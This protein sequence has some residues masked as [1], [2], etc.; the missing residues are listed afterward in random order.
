MTRREQLLK[1]FDLY[2]EE[3]ERRVAEGIEKNRKGD[4]VLKIVDGNGSPVQG[5][6][7]K[8]TLKKHAFLFGGNLYGLDQLETPEKNALYREKFKQVFNMATLPIYWNTLEPEQGKPR[9]AKDSPFIYRRPPVDL[10][11]EYCEENGIRPK[12][13]C[14]NYFYYD[15]YPA[16]CPRD[17]DTTEIRQLCEKRFAELAARYKER[18]PDWEVINETLG[19]YI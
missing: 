15:H 2:R 18:I 16:W 11:L 4:A 1:H 8:A 10:C 12:A 19:S 7:V 14:L 6:R 3:T 13:H 9:F 5:A 17:T